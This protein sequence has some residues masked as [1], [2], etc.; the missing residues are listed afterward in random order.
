[1][2]ATWL[3]VLKI[4]FGRAAGRIADADDGDVAGGVS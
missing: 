3:S 2:S 1:M 4:G